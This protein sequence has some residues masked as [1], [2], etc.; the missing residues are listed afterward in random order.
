V[1]RTAALF[2]KRLRNTPFAADFDF[3]E[4]RACNDGPQAATP[5]AIIACPPVRKSFR[6]LIPDIGTSSE[7]KDLRPTY[8]LG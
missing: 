2:A 6:R 4:D 8:S 5:P 7:L 1:E 3:D